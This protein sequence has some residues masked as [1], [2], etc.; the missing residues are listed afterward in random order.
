M[1]DRRISNGIGAVRHRA[2]AH[3]NFRSIQGSDGERPANLSRNRRYDIGAD[4]RDKTAFAKARTQVSH[5][6]CQAINAP[7]RISRDVTLLTQGHQYSVNRRLWKRCIVVQLLKRRIRST[8][9]RAQH[10]ERPSY[11]LNDGLRQI[12]TS[13][14]L[15]ER[16]RKS[17]NSAEPAASMKRL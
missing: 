15:P 16:R 10:V 5:L 8:V 7:Y 1:V 12:N 3:D 2:V 14:I 17:I 9:K 11:R 4:I 6:R 13:P